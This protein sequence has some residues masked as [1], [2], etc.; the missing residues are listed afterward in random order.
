MTIE[1]TILEMINHLIQKHPGLAP[2]IQT[3]VAGKTEGGAVPSSI[4]GHLKDLE[5]LYLKSLQSDN[6]YAGEF[7]HVRSVMNRININ[8]G[9]VVDIAASD[10]VT[11]SCTLELFKDPNWSGLAVEMDPVKFSGLSFIY[12]AFPNARLARARVVPSNVSSLLAGFEVPNDFDFLNLD[13]DSYDLHVIRSALESGFRPKMISMEINEKIP[14][15]IY[16]TVDFSES[17]YWAGDHFFGCSL[18]AAANTV[19]PFGYVLESCQYN[20][21][22]FVR[23]DLANGVIEDVSVRDAY[24]QGYKNKPDRA[25]LFSYN[26]DVD[27]LLDCP[28]PEALA[29]IK[30]FF[31]KYEGKYT[32]Y[33]EGV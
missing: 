16:F 7:A 20:N 19:K 2:T 26:K 22:M 4:A 24:E 29:F 10:G 31:A 33:A 15:E 9:F 25:S 11:L 14:P 17:H 23:T 5:R 1:V 27:I 3:I 12:G 21:A 18:L 30:T 13:I 6:S 32:L 28:T 8:G